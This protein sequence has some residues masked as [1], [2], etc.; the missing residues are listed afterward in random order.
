MQA[1]FPHALQGAERLLAKAF[2]K[3][4]D[5]VA[6]RECDECLQEGFEHEFDE[7][8][9][10]AR[11]VGNGEDAIVVG[12]RTRFPA[13]TA[14]TCSKLSELF[15]MASEAWML[16]SRFSRRSRGNGGS[17]DLM[18]RRPISSPIPA[19]RSRMRGVKLV[20]HL[21]RQWAL[22]SFSGNKKAA[23]HS[24]FSARMECSTSYGMT[25]R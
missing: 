2:D 17:A 18:P 14:V 12:L 20:V 7:S 3:L 16:R 9:G 24:G 15:S 4:G 25:G 13:I 19:T 22:I 11:F 1:E 23:S 8:R 10:F 6:R 5:L 21:V